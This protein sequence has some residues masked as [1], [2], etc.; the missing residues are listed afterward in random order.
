MSYRLQTLV[1]EETNSI[2]D[3]LA[4]CPADIALER[5]LL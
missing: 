3:L 2:S 1:L 5:T 4:K